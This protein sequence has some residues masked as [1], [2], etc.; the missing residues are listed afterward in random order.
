[1]FK[2]NIL[3]LNLFFMKKVKKSENLTFGGLL[4]SILLLCGCYFTGDSCSQ[5]LIYINSY[6]AT[7]NDSQT[8]LLARK[9]C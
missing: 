4:C 7:F 1:M 8:K 3:N 5:L 2:N 6:G 9:V